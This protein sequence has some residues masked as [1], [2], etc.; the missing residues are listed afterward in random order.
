MLVHQK[1]MRKG[2]R[3]TGITEEQFFKWYKANSSNEPAATRFAHSTA[4]CCVTYIPLMLV[5]LSVTLLVLSTTD[6]VEVGVSLRQVNAKDYIPQSVY[7]Q[8]EPVLKTVNFTEYLDMGYTNTDEYLTNEFGVDLATLKPLIHNIIG[9]GSEGGD[10][11][12]DVEWDI[13]QS[14][15]YTKAQETLMGLAPAAQSVVGNLSGHIVGF[16]MVLVSLISNSINMLLHLIFFI[17]VLN[18]LLSRPSSIFCSQGVEDAI[19]EDLAQEINTMIAS[20]ISL[21]CK[22]GLSH[23]FFTYVVFV[24]LG[25]PQ[26][27]LAMF[28]S[29]VLGIFPLVSQHIVCIF[30]GLALLLRACYVKTIMFVVLWFV[31]LS[32]IDGYLRGSAYGSTSYVM[33][34]ATVFAMSEFGLDGVIVGPLALQSAFLAAETYRRLSRAKTRSRTVEVT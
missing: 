26:M 27:H 32:K 31:G 18:Y 23:C 20:V 21:P 25:I 2:D 15:N 33:L 10:S 5:I 34:L 11:K 9:D 16:L 7:D 29:L 28:L 8:V 4:I 13:L 3:D 24:A 17:K 19:G 14:F 6:A 1:S 12:A 30:W 22:I